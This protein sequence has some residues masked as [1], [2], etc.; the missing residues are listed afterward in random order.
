MDRDRERQMTAATDTGRTR[1]P[2]PTALDTV[3]ARWTPD[4]ETTPAT[5]RAQTRRAATLLATTGDRLTRADLVDR[6]ADAT[7]LD[8]RTWWEHAAG[9]G[10]E[11][12]AD[13]DLVDTATGGFRWTGPDTSEGS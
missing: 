4:T 2:Q 12:L 10:L 8:R 1:T 13:R 5:A 9:P 7:A 6:L 3:L 11:R